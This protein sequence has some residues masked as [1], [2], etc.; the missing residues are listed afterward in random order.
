MPLIISM[1]GETLPT[2]Y[3]RR[4]THRDETHQPNV[5]GSFGTR[6]IPSDGGP[7]VQYDVITELVFPS[8][9][10]SDAWFLRVNLG[11]NGEKVRDDEE[12]FLDRGRTTAFIVE[13]HVTR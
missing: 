11:E 12:V 8:K 2:T 9:E 5:T 10:A 7:G 1:S 3:K 13:E 6:L 4:Y